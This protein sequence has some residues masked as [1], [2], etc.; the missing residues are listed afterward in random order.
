MMRQVKSGAVQGLISASTRAWVARGRRLAFAGTLLALACLL[1]AP[2]E[3]RAQPAQLAGTPYLE[4]DLGDHAG[5]IRRIAVDPRNEL[6]A[7]ASDD[8]TARSWSLARGELQRV[9]R[10]RVGTGDIGRVYGV[11]F[12]PTEPWVAIGGTSPNAPIGVYDFKTGRLVRWI[13]GHAGAVK[14][15]AWSPDGTLLFAAFAQSGALAAFALDGTRQ[16][17]DTFGADVYALAVAKGRVAAAA[18][19]GTLRVY[20]VAGGAAQTEVRALTRIQLPRNPVSLGF[21]P[22]A[23]ALAVGYFAQGKPPDIVAWETGRVDSLPVPSRMDTEDLRSVAWSPDSG[24]VVAGGS[25]G[26]ARRQVQAVRYDAIERKLLSQA[27]AARSSITDIAAMPGDRFVFASADGAWGM[28]DASGAQPLTARGVR[29]PMLPDLDGAAN[30]KV[31]ADGNQLSWTLDAGANRV[32]FDLRARR[33]AAGEGASLSAP[34]I[35]RGLFDAAQDWENRT[36]PLINRQR[37]ALPAGEVSRAVALFGHGSDAVLGTSHALSRVGGD[38]RVLWRVATH[39]EVRAV[40]IARDDR[41]I[42]TTMLDGTVRLWRSADGAQLVSLLAL[43]DGR[44]IIWTPDGFFD[45]SVGADGLAGWVINRSGDEEPAFFPMARLRERLQQ[46]RY[47]D[48]L[49]ESLDPAKA[50]LA[51][52]SEIRREAV[53]TAVPIAPQP[54]AQT[55]ALTDLFPP[56]LSST[57]PSTSLVVQGATGRDGSGSIEVPIVVSANAPIA[58]LTFEARVEGRPARLEV[59]K[60]PAAT[61]G[62]S[63]GVLRVELQAP[64]SSVQLLARDPNGYSEPLSFA[65]AWPEPIVEQPAPAAPPVAQAAETPKPSTATTPQRASTK[66]QPRLFLLSIGVS[67]Y[68]RPDYKLGLAAKD[69]R[70]FAEL[71]SAQAGRF[72]LDVTAKVL[73]DGAARRTS[74]LEGLKWLAG[75]AGP[76]DVAML[77]IA[78]HGLNA[79]NGKYYFLPHDARHEDLEHTAIAEDAIREAMRSVAGRAI[80]FVD[81]CF[82]GNVLGPLKDR[83]REL[84]RFVNDLASAENGVVVFA[85]SSGRQLSEEHEGLDNGA[86]TSALLQGLKGKADL[87]HSGRVTFKGLDYFVSEEVKRL[88]KGRQTPV[89]L[90]PWGVPDFALAA[91]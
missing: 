60:V 59:V 26:V 83:N 6:V 84:S 22:D 63:P 17:A 68:A 8:R 70:D 88:T 82:A 36:T 2:A 44:W 21:S 77:F 65:L 34:S 58:A 13:G 39:T 3:P 12:H 49:L 7:T 79:S 69:A 29:A 32:L 31:S 52:E 67:E 61:N 56:L 4:V 11:A 18:L 73:V 9:F 75:A 27:A 30:L 37:M 51:L 25:F 40:N 43:R 41:L 80:F 48:L 62:R 5:A 47:I 28:L 76:G 20:A 86:F 35:R 19:D 64:A 24:V 33:L 16:F 55:Q 46:P 81:T 89:S 90:A 57:L 85:S 74:V 23:K 15:L 78:G 45:A 71:L 53:A 87:L 72:Y 50:A 1:L 66:R 10:L 91:I 38:G 14:R 54:A 42:V